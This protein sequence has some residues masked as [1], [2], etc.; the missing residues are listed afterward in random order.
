VFKGSDRVMSPSGESELISLLT[1][2][3]SDIR[4]IKSDLQ[5]LLR[6]LKQQQQKPTPPPSSSTDDKPTDIERA[7]SGSPEDVLRYLRLTRGEDDA[8]E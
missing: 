3:R 6:H 7:Q 2:I 1:E 8:G 4:Q 5:S